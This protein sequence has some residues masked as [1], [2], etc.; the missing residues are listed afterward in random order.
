MK[1]FPSRLGPRERI[2]YG[3]ATVY[4]F[5][6]FLALVWPVYPLFSHI[7]PTVLGLPFSLAYIVFFIVLSFFVLLALYLWESRTGRLD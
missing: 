6:V 3:A 2:I 7:F 1:L 4:F 5:F